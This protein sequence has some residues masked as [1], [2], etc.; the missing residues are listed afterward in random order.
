LHRH[1][2]ANHRCNTRIRACEIARGHRI[3][4][5][6][7]RATAGTRTWSI[8]LAGRI[9]PGWHPKLQPGELWKGYTAFASAGMIEGTDIIRRC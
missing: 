5:G 3:D 8:D 1:A 4:P 2:S 6:A 7:L 9:E